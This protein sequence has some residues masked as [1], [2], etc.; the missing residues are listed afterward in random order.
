MSLK[1]SERS[2]FDRS[3]PLLRL[4]SSQ[5][6]PELM[7]VP[8]EPIIHLYRFRQC[9]FCMEYHNIAGGAI[10]LVKHNAQPTQCKMSALRFFSTLPAFSRDYSFCF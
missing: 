10:D 4:L 6:F 1:V 3:S 2:L 8:P 5:Y 9:K 7:F